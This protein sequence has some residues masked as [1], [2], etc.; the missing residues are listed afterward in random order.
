MIYLLWLLLTVFIYSQDSIVVHQDPPIDLGTLIVDEG[1][2]NICEDDTLLIVHIYLPQDSVYSD[3][4]TIPADTVCIPTI[5]EINDSSAY[6]IIPG[7]QY[8]GRTYSPLEANRQWSGDPN[9]LTVFSGDTVL[10]SGYHNGTWTMQ[11]VTNVVFLFKDFTLD[12]NNSSG[13][14]WSHQNLSNVEFH[15]INGDTSNCRVISFTDHHIFAQT[16]DNLFY[17][18]INILTGTAGQTDG[19]Y[20]QTTS[21]IIIANSRVRIINTV[22]SEHA[23]GIQLFKVDG[24]R[25]FWNNHIEHSAQ[26]F[27]N[28]QG[29]FDEMQLSN[30]IGTFTAKYN[31]IK[32]GRGGIVLR[33]KDNTRRGDA[34]VEFNIID[35]GGH[36]HDIWLNYP[37][38]YNPNIHQDN[39]ASEITIN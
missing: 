32:S 12:G 5:I 3:T 25:T 4:L 31:W 39:V 34:L 11:D 8:Y 9:A 38:S 22:G 37:V 36:G 6:G 19:F 21:N 23:D 20:I 24:D 18:G 14:A 13:R 10:M 26:T 2:V 28:K 27:A 29:I 1:E 16:S 15:S 7:V 33:N 35:A 30:F 17:D